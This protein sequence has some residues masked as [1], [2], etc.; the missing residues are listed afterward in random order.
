MPRLTF[1]TKQA[2]KSGQILR[3][4]TFKKSIRIQN[5]DYQTLVEKHLKCKNLF[6]DDAFPADLTSIGSENLLQNLPPCVTWKRPHE[7]VKNPQFFADNVSRFKLHQGLTQNCW[8]LAALSSLTLNKDILTKVVP[9]NQSFQKNYTGIF[10]FKFWRFGEWID[11]VVDDRLPVDENGKLIFVSCAKNNLFWGALL[12][13]AYAKL[14]GSYEDMQIGEVSEA[15]VDFTGGVNITITLSKAP[16]DLWNIMLRAANSGSL[17][18]C[19]THSGPEM[20]MENGLVAGHAYAVT[21]IRKV[22]SKLGA[23]YLVRLRNP[24]GKVEWNGNWSRRS[25]KWEQLSFKERLLLQK[26]R[27]D[28]EFW[29][30]N[31]D[32]KDNFV[33][34]AIC[35]LTPDL[36][37]QEYGKQW[38]LS[39]QSGKWSSGSTAGGGRHCTE[40]YWRNPQ[41]RLKTLNEDD[42]EK[43]TDSS[44]V[45][46]S[47]IQ[48]QNHK[49]RN[50]SPLLFIGVSIFQFQGTQSR[51]PK[52]F[53]VNHKPINNKCVYAN[54]PHFRWTMREQSENPNTG[55]CWMK[56]ADKQEDKIWENVFAKFFGKLQT[57]LSKGT[58]PGAKLFATPF[59]LDT[60]KVIMAQLD[61]NTSGT[62]N[63]DEFQNLWER[64]ISYKEIFQRRDIN[65]SG[66]LTM[67]DLQAATEEKEPTKHNGLA[68]Y[69]RNVLFKLRNCLNLCTIDRSSFFSNQGITLSHQFSNLM[70]LRYGNSSLEVD[71]ENFVCFMLRM[72]INREVQISLE[73]FQNLSHDGKGIYLREA[74]CI[75]RLRSDPRVQPASFKAGQDAEA[76]AH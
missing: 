8:I 71:Y 38:M 55:V 13:K 30:S 23:E 20:I 17:M 10:H 44:H 49:H 24:W 69:R 70:I 58:W 65:R 12:E 7:L 14:C 29:I 67:I 68:V 60:C 18:G 37:S 76:T 21:G 46:I 61:L 27:E 40:S 6:E 59:S 48:K 32:F 2:K 45:L 1:K 33:E 63:M 73:L 36:I 9:Q 19:Q 52:S 15:L 47:L 22:T 39:M 64:L 56:I 74:E 26:A 42:M 41:Y 75:A 11:V 31:E 34:L 16:A 57:L 28:G 54:H 3:T 51:L 4:E 62:L 25:Q 66:Y 43:N 5:Q 72:E 53:F 35:K 50:Q